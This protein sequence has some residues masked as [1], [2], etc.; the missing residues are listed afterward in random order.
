MFSELGN[1][2]G[3]CVAVFMF[4]F[5]GGLSSLAIQPLLA[6]N[7]SSSHFSQR[8]LPGFDGS[9]VVCLPHAEQRR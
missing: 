2:L 1:Q 9:F 6:S 5:V 8:R 4:H 3:K 7:G